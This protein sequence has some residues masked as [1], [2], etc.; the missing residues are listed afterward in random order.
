MSAETRPLQRM[1]CMTEG[2]FQERV[3]PAS[4]DWRRSNCSRT[5]VGGRARGAS[6]TSSPRV[7]EFVAT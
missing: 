2:R 1:R 4:P 5:Q 6:L 3:L 7:G